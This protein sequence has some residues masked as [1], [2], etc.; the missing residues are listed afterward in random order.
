MRKHK[1]GG[2][3]YM[4]NVKF[5]TVDDVCRFIRANSM[6]GEWTLRGEMIRSR[7]FCPVCWIAKKINPESPHTIIIMAAMGASG[8]PMDEALAID[9]AALA[10]ANRYCSIED[11][12][13]LL[14]ACGLIS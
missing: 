5:N 2:S 13:K 10:D 4:D 12:R 9:V 6:L 11:R 7:G 14:V 8:W 3:E 1:K